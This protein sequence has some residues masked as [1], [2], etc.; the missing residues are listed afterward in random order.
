MD[1]RDRLDRLDRLHAW[2]R[3]L[4]FRVVTTTMLLGMLVLGA[5]GSYLYQR[6]GD[7]LVQGRAD[8]ATAEAVQLTVT[9]QAKFYSTDKTQNTDALTIAA[10]SII[11]EIAG[12]ERSR[13]AATGS[14]TSTHCNGNGRPSRS[15]RRSSSPVGSF[16]SCSSVPWLTS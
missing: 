10:Q 8:L 4:Q 2:R 3:S 5:V 15:S 11:G 7:R 16:S 14:T 6:I 12:T 1:R 9:A 13:Y